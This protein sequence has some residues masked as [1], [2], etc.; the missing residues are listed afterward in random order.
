MKLFFSFLILFLQIS[1]LSA[2]IKYI[3]VNK[4]SSANSIWINTIEDF[5]KLVFDNS[6]STVFVKHDYNGQDSGRHYSDNKSSVFVAEKNGIF[7]YFD[8]QGYNSIADL[9]DAKRKGYNS[10]G[11]FYEAQKLGFSEGKFYYLYKNN[12]FNS[13]EDCLDA[14]EKGFYTEDKLTGISY[15][16]D[17][18]N[19][20]EYYDAKDKNLESF[21]AYKEFLDYT[22]K[23]FK[24]KEDFLT[25]QKKGFTKGTEYYNAV[26]EG[27]S[28]YSDYTE[29]HSL[30]LRDEKQWST[31]K[32]IR[33]EIDSIMTAKQ[34]NKKNA[35]VCFCMGKLKKGEMSLQIL[36]D[37]LKE[38]INQFDANILNA[39]FLTIFE[40]ENN[41]NYSSM[42]NS[43]KLNLLY[44]LVAVN[45]LK[46]FFRIAKVNEIGNYNEKTDIFKRNGNEK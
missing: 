46:T 14:F 29:A 27:F 45:N 42:G 37:S 5:E 31:F 24:T 12:S 4:I 11:E 2:E 34:L 41:Y 15:S 6:I 19:S 1:F 36:S 18:K 35:F 28:S 7:F 25:A 13:V 32:S 20:R 10:S 38:I 33:N 8:A 43:Q 17:N 21:A 3:P 26:L 40:K 39:V 22:A 44:D 23:G 30:N 16:K 9:K